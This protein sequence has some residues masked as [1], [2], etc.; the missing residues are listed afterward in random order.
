MPKQKYT[1]KRERMTFRQLGEGLRASERRIQE[2]QQINIDALK[3]AALRQ[4]KLDNQFIS[5][6]SDKHKFEEGVLREKQ[7]LENKA[8]TRKYEA[9]TKFADTDVA[10]MEGEAKALKQKAE[11]W[12]DFA[13]KFAKNLSKLAEG[14]WYFQDKIKG[15][16]YLKQW[17]ESGAGKQFTDGVAGTEYGVSENALLDRTKLTEEGQHELSQNIGKKIGGSSHWFSLRIADWA[18]QNK[19]AIRDDII[20]SYGK[21]N[22]TADNAVEVQ[23]YGTHL[24]LEKIGLPAKSAGA[25]QMLEQ[26]TQMGLLDRKKII[27]MEKV[28]TTDDLIQ[29]G[30]ENIQVAL[31]NRNNYSGPG[32]PLR[33]MLKTQLLNKLNGTFKTKS[34]QIDSPL[35]YARNKG[36]EY[37]EVIQETIQENYKWMSQDDIDYLLALEVPSLKGEKTEPYNKKFSVQAQEDEELYNT[38]KEKQFD[39]QLNI[40][41]RDSLAEGDKVSSDYKA[42]YEDNNIVPNKLQFYAEVN[43]ILDNPK[44]LPETKKAKLYELGVPTEQYDIIGHIANIDEQVILGNINEATRLLRSGEITAEQRVRILKEIKYLDELQKYGPIGNSTKGG[45]L[46]WWEEIDVEYERLAGKYKSTGLGKD[47]SSSAEYSKTE[48]KAYVMKKYLHARKKGMSLEEAIEY[49]EAERRKEWDRGKGSNDTEAGEGLFAR[50]LI[51]G[52]WI[53]PRHESI[54]QEALNLF[55][56]EV[57]RKNEPDGKWLTLGDL[58]LKDGKSAIEHLLTADPGTGIGDGYTDVKQVLTSDR[59]TNDFEMKRLAQQIRN[60]NLHTS[61]LKGKLAP[62]DLDVPKGFHIVAKFYGLDLSEA[63]NIWIESK[64]NDPNWAY[65]KDVRVP[66]TSASAAKLINNDKKVRE[67]DEIGYG[68]FNSIRAVT[69]KMPAKH[70]VYAALDKME[71][72]QDP[73][74]VTMSL[75]AEK[76]GIKYWQ[77]EDG[78]WRFSDSAGLLKNGGLDL[79]VGANPT[80]MLETI[81]FDPEALLLSYEERLKRIQKYNRRMKGYEQLPFWMKL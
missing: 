36:E 8:R 3:L 65:L 57:D 47:P 31:K 81:K 26:S 73:R 45:L 77:G 32:N 55:N 16:E 46:G 25:Q 7:E 22:Y 67:G 9:F 12:K 35:D 78:H 66:L 72:N 1:P 64:A 38:L 74:S 59:L 13:P 33:Q 17:I 56:S 40:Q 21:D 62:M 61:T 50:K 18:R 51:G 39:D 30:K 23:R 44:L 5:G 10:R 43:V 19:E 60:D 69:R 80:E 15:Q 58:T 2:Q 20:A 14:A 54:D 24:L 28:K 27:D 76:T 48:Y 71:D 70:E 75:F 29:L 79:P 68:Y 34:G 11:F 4:E 63:V 41:K 6:L 37:R 49:V 52:K 42:K 53:F